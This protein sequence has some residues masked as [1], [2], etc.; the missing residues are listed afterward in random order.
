MLQ[1]LADISASTE[2]RVLEVTQ[3]YFLKISL[4]A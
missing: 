2:L 1:M 3:L 4:Y